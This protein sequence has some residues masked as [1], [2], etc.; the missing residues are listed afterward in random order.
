MSAELIIHNS[1]SNLS[2]SFS[3]IEDSVREIKD[4][5]S[6]Q[7]NYY[8]VD[9]EKLNKDIEKYMMNAKNKSI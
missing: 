5:F 1:D 2:L 8:S 9:K 4:N 6:Y 3:M 7:Q